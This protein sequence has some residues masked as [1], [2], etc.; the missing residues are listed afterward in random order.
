MKTG[1]DPIKRGINPAPFTAEFGS[2][3]WRK[4]G[5]PPCRG[6]DLSGQAEDLRIQVLGD[7]CAG[8]RRVCARSVRSLV[9]RRIRFP[10]DPLRAGSFLPVLQCVSVTKTARA[11]LGGPFRGE[12]CDMAGGGGIDIVWPLLMQ[13][14]VTVLLIV[15]ECR[16]PTY[17]GVLSR[18]I[19]SRNIERYLRGEIP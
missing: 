12:L 3:G 7:R 9:C 16:H 4:S 18:R 11:V 13:I 5:Y 1:T 6:L 2:E 19:N 15:L 10:R 8:D 14:P 17:H